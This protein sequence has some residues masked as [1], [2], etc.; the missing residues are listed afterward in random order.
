MSFGRFILAAVCGSAVTFWGLFLASILSD[1][2]EGRVH[3]T[4]MVH[5]EFLP[6]YLVALY[7]P[8]IVAAITGYLALRN[9]VRNAAD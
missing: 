1:Y 4:G 6:G 2:G 9:T 8:P 7:A 3:W 5:G